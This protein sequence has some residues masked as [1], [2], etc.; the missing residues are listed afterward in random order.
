[1]LNVFETDV[2]LPD[3][4]DVSLAA[5]T[6]WRLQLV[7]FWNLRLWATNIHYRVLVHLKTCGETCEERF[8]VL[9]A[10]RV[11]SPGTFLEAFKTLETPHDV[12]SQKTGIYS[13]L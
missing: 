12:T 8:K 3:S 5:T 6:P 4:S 1:M 11:P 9:A 2:T 7:S 10:V 13:L